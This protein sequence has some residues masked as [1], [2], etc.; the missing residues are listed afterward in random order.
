MWNVIIKYRHSVQP[1]R[2]NTKNTITAD[3]VIDHANTLDSGSSTIVDRMHRTVG[4]KQ[5]IRS[6]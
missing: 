6:D 4:I 2:I 5:L 3:S 1:N